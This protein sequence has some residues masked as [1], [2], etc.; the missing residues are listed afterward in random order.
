M[1]RDETKLVSVSVLALMC[2]SGTAFAQI[3]EVDEEVTLEAVIVSGV[4]SRLP[5]E[6]SSFPG[7]VTL[8][9]EET[10][11]AQ[12]AITPDVG[13]MLAFEVPGL[14]TAS[15]SSSDYGQ[16]MRGR[17]VAFYV[18]GVPI[19]VPL[20]DAGRAMRA[21]SGSALQGVEVIRGATAL[22]GNGGTGGSVNYITTRP[23]GPD[24]VTGSTDV[25]LS[26]SL[27]NPS[28]SY[29]PRVEQSITALSGPVDFIAVGSYES[30]GAFFDADGDRIISNPNG[31][32]GISE[33]DIYNL[34]S[35]AGLTLDQHR[36]EGSVMIYDQ[37][38]D[39]DWGI[40]VPG[41]QQAGIKAQAAYGQAD[42]REVGEYNKNLVAQAS[43]INSDVLGGTMRAQVFTQDINQL[44]SFNATRAG[45]SQSEIRS[46]KDGVRLEFNTPL[47]FMNQDN[48]RILWGAEYV[49]DKSVQVVNTTPEQIF[50]PELDQKDLAAFAQV[51]FE[52]MSDLTIQGG[53]RY[54]SFDVEVE[55]FTVL[56]TGLNVMGGSTD[57]E[58][59]VFN[60]GAVKGINENLDIYAGYSQG[61]SLPDIGRTLR[62][63]TVVN[64]LV[65]F[66]PE[67][68]KIDSYEI[69]IRGDL[70]WFSYTFAGFFSESELGQQFEPDPNDLLANIVVRAAEEVQGVEGTL[71]G[72][73][74]DDQLAWGGTFTYVTGETDTDDDGEVDSPLDNSRIP[75]VKVTGYVNYQL[76]DDWS[77][78][79]QAIYS[80]SRNE[81]PDI[82]A[83]STGSYGDVEPFTVFDVSTRFG[84]GA[85]DMTLSLSNALNNDYF[86]ESSTRSGNRPLRYAPAPGAT[87]KVGYKV[88]Y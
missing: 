19:S 62:S 46:R 82:A 1:Y 49:R 29:R 60:I 79:V 72:A 34:Y 44:F 8:I 58:S 4:N 52:L 61:F 78:R 69:G 32:G 41:D 12:L 87:F 55:D 24:G 75:P 65:T 16:T 21:V 50:V 6:L 66:R 31:N 86:P 2:L 13:Q 64:P 45:G 81:F 28:D 71:K 76:R 35:R 83:T 11:D 68:I 38:Q 37:E 53:V 88:S 9:D 15:F 22:Y 48:S 42:P 63:T 73:F 27:T 33:S 20:R 51:E 3:E 47:T 5:N 25:S 84:F 14:G 56:T 30:L 57:Y 43:Y 23:S 80:G 17:P 40:I 85:G 74:M 36:F 77:V 54:D 10:L 18:D 59:T 7:S 39:T 70:P 67:P 26:A